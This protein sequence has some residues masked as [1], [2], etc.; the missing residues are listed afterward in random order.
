LVGCPGVR[1]GLLH[2]IE[3]LCNLA[4]EAAFLRLSDIRDP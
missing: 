4:A 3:S 2:A 1:R